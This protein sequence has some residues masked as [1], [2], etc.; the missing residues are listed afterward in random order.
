MARPSLST[1][2]DSLSD[3]RSRWL[4][5]DERRPLSIDRGARLEHAADLFRRNPESRFIVVVKDGGIPIGALMERDIRGLLLNPYGHAL[6]CNP[7]YGSNLDDHVRAVPIADMHCPAPELIAAYR[8]G[9]GSEGMILTR[10][11]RLY[12]TLSNRRLV[13]LAAT[14]EVERARE[15]VRQAARIESASAAFDT[16][17]ARLADDLGT[18]AAAVAAHAVAAGNRAGATGASAAAMAMTASDGADHLDRIEKEG[19]SLLSALA[20][21]AEESRAA[22]ALVADAVMMVGDG[23]ARTAALGRSADSI[24]SIA[25]IIGTI[26]AEVNMLA[27]NARIEAARAGEAGRGFAVVAASI[28][29]LSAQTARAAGTVAS[30]V[31]DVQAA[32]ADVAAAHARIEEAVHEIAGRSAR[33]TDA[34]EIQLAA[35]DVI[36]AHVAEAASGAAATHAQAGIVGENARLAAASSTAMRSLADRLTVQAGSVAA[37]AHAFLHEVRGELP[38]VA[39]AA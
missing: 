1:F 2:A 10:D 25:Q 16:E 12:A 21:V 27:L 7:A 24:G 32:V 29:Q 31:D 39:A 36:T 13:L 26:A 19:R 3:P 35:M 9:N 14:L 30:H 8:A 28:K 23:A 4:A 37:K 11:G 22:R 34:A 17:V 38:A 33:I 5:D 20:G 6:L 15:R 18:L